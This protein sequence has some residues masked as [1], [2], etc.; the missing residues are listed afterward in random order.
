MIKIISFGHLI[1]LSIRKELGDYFKG[2][3]INF[4]EQKF[5][6]EMNKPTMNQIIKLVLPTIN[7]D[8]EIPFIILPGT[9]V[10]S[11]L[12]ISLMYGYFGQFP[13]IV[14]LTR[15]GEEHW[16]WVVKEIHDLNKLKS[17]I[18]ERRIK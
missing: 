10:S 6:L 14:E 3:E 8:S 16:K 18:R 15:S 9:S 4:I 13:F 17:K 12:I 7:G 5:Q 11:G 1:P 2:K